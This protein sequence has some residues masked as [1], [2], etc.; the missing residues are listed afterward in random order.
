MNSSAAYR[1]GSKMPHRLSDVRRLYDI[2]A[3]LERRMGGARRL[4]ECNG[5]M[6]WPSRGIYFFLEDGEERSDSGLGQRVVRVGTHALKR[7]SRTTLW[8]R[9]AQHR[10]VESTGGGNHRGSIFRLLV[11]SALVAVEPK[12]HCSSW[13][14]G[15]SAPKNVRAR[16]ATLEMKVSERIRRMQVLVSAVTDEPGP[17]S[18]RGDLE[19][20]A[21]ALLSNFGRAPVD[22]ALPTW[23][24]AHCPRE[25]VRRSGLWNSNHVSEVYDPSFL[26]RLSVAVRIG[27]RG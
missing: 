25:R 10:G 12:L 21:I 1:P 19:H 13:G 23:L 27:G 9:L 16:E 24:G 22:P 5:R 11:G 6:P 4:G 14:Q 20:N 3:E 26:T 17:R 15:S 7:R 8:K 18:L 2:L